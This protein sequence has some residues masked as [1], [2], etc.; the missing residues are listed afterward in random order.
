MQIER[1]LDVTGREEEEEEEVSSYWMI[2]REREDTE[3]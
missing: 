1:R 3:I 2:F